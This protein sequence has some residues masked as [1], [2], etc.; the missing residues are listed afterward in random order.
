MMRLLA[1]L[2]LTCLLPLTSGCAIFGYAAAVIPGPGSKARYGGLAGQRVA[3]IAWAERAVTYD[4]PALTSDT[5]MGTQNKIAAAAN[6]TLK[7]EELKGT[8]FVDPRQVLRWQK[9]HPELANRSVAEIAPQA[10]AAFGCTRMVYI[11]VT[12]FSVYDPRTPVLLKGSASLTIR[13][14][15]LDHEGHAHIG[16]EEQGV[17]A[18][19]PDKAPEGVPPTDTMTASYVYKGLVDTITTEAAKRFFSSAPGEE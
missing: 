17:L 2:G 11:E 4:Y 5:A 1:I 14:A 12:P 16:Y 9:N 15:E 8:T 3:V 10:F 19:F 13:V 7:L 18:E 6:P